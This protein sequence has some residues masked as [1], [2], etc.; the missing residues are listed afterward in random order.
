MEWIKYISQL[1][2]L[3]EN[4]TVTDRHGN[5]LPYL[6]GLN[7]LNENT[8]KVRERQNSVFLI[9]NG[10]SA[11]MASHIAADLYKSTSV[12]TEVFTDIA[13]LTAFANDYS[14]DDVFSEPL[15]RKIKQD[16]M[17]VAISS[18]GESKNILN[19]TD[20][21]IQHDGFLVTLSAMQQ[22]NSLRLKGDLNFYINA[23]T[24]GK[25]EICHT[26]I[27]HYWIDSVAAIVN[28][29]N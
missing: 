13:L 3:L 19:A 17:L 22:D 28:G 20:I 10:A 12:R 15:K 16:D 7:S 21:A 5:E 8:L 27:L 6:E 25:A 1:N 24:Y 11:T 18:S 4:L 29:K 9:G 26:A 23:D 14:Y 2:N